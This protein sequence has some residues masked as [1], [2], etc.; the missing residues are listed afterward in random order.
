VLIKCQGK[1]MRKKTRYCEIH[2]LLRLLQKVRTNYSRKTE[3]GFGTF[4]TR[5]PVR[6]SSLPTSKDGPVEIWAKTTL[7]DSRAQTAVK[8]AT[9]MLWAYCPAIITLCYVKQICIQ[10]C[11][12]SC[13]CSQRL[14]SQ[15]TRCITNWSSKAKLSCVLHSYKQI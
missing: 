5:R 15:P 6:P 9:K 8:R 3:V 13:K 1:R 4:V 11:R 10:W 2:T 14:L 12:P 7:T